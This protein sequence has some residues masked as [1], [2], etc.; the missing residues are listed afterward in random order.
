MNVLALGKIAFVLLRVHIRAFY[1]NMKASG[2]NFLARI[3]V[4]SDKTPYRNHQIMGMVRFGTVR[5]LESMDERGCAPL[6][7]ARNR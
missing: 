4:Q 5:F 6:G 3:E 2:S 7:L 1:Q